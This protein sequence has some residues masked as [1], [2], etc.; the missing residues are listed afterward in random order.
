MNQQPAKDT[1]K[2]KPAWCKQNKTEWY[3]R[4]QKEN[5]FEGGMINPIE[6][7]GKLT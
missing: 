1:E 5:G 3:P 2:E 7:W 4:S 6:S